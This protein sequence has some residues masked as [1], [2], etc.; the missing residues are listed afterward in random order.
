[1]SEDE[2]ATHGATQSPDPR[3]AEVLRALNRARG[4]VGRVEVSTGSTSPVEPIG[5]SQVLR[6]WL[7]R[8]TAGTEDTAQSLAATSRLLERL[9]GGAGEKL[10]DLQRHQDAIVRELRDTV[11][12]L[13]RHA[14]ELAAWRGW[15]TR[16]MATW[17]L[18][19]ALTV[20]GGVGIAWRAYRLANSTH[21]ILEQILENQ[22]KAR[23]DKSG[24][25]M[26]G[27]KPSRHRPGESA[28]VL[29]RVKAEPGRPGGLDAPCALP[30]ALS[31]RCRDSKTA[32]AV[33]QQ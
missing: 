30:C 27:R 32:F 24:K 28:G 8:T 3:T 10:G 19:L 20:A 23:A 22:A 11:H 14:D 6:E 5:E 15:W 12:E 29:G 7:W 16:L 1:M 33:E 18:V 4:T 13:R 31:C 25:L 17:G 2:G 9:V 21:D 26:R